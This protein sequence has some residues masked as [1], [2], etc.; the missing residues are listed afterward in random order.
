MGYARITSTYMPLR[1]AVVGAGTVSG[2]HLSGVRK[3]PRT[4]LV[5]ICDVDG[6]RAREVAEEY[7]IRSFTSVDALL[8]GTDLDW[9]HVCTPVQTHLDIAEQAIAAGVPV[10]IEKPVTVSSAEFERLEEVA[11]THDVPVSVVHNHV[12]TPAM[13]T[14]L[15]RVDAGAIGDVRG[16]DVVFTGLTKPDEPNRGSWTFDLLG[17]EF[18]EGLPHPIYLTLRAGGYPRSAAVV[19]ATT[20]LVGDYDGAFAYDGA[21]LQY[22]SE[23]GALCTT[24][25][26]S[27][28]LPQRFVHVHGTQGS[29][30]VDLVSQ[31][32]MDVD[33]DY[34]TSPVARARN[35]LDR[36]VDLVG[37]LVENVRS[38]AAQRRSDDW[39][40]ATRLNAHYYQIDAESRALETG[41]EM[42]VPL[43]QAKWTTVLLDE[44]R[45]S[46]REAAA[47]EPL[48]AMDD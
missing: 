15:A 39:G 4:K 12:F 32:V 34:T 25:M 10:Q 30:T 37:G 47:E 9:V 2:A 43:D 28:T 3:N 31:T 42:P 41:T 5:A 16:V 44:V 23:R 45:R 11:A 1:T 29:L 7:G 24:T 20:S 14:A 33:R 22:E 27:G 40:T 38:V 36:V 8:S 6:A 26:L 13:R 48:Q 21:T 18:E 19:R 46:A 17:G 35:N